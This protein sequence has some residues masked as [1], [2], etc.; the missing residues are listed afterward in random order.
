MLKSGNYKRIRPKREESNFNMLIQ[1]WFFMY[2]PLVNLI[3]VY[4]I[5]TQQDKIFNHD[6]KLVETEDK[7]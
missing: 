3:L 5:I 6:Y 4:T 7:E 2:L 1:C